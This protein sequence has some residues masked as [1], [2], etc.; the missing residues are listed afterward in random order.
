MNPVNLGAP[1]NR[2]ANSKNAT[3]NVKG[4]VVVAASR[5]VVAANVVAVNREMAEA[6]KAVAVSKVAAVSKAAASKGEDNLII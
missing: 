3:R 4:K 2:E 5:A 6:S 1:A